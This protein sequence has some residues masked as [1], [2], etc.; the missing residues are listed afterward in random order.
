MPGN[1]FHNMIGRVMTEAQGVESG[2]DFM[3]LVCEDGSK[4]EFYHEQDCC[5]SVSIYDVSG[6]PLDLVGSPIVIAE[7]ISSED[8]PTD[9]MPSD[10]YTWTFYKFATAKGFVTVRWLGESN[11]YYSEGVSYRETLAHQPEP[12]KIQ[13][14]EGKQMSF[15]VDCNG[16]QVV[17]KNLPMEVILRLGDFDVKLCLR[18]E[19]KPQ[20]DVVVLHDDPTKSDRQTLTPEETQAFLKAVSS[21][22]LL[23]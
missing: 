6:D 23:P 13:E 21:W 19:K 15:H 17:T 7:A 10:S 3:T 2:S 4:F 18:A 20:I 14:Q 16:T 9:Y 12:A 8:P 1:I 5:E 22:L 11:G